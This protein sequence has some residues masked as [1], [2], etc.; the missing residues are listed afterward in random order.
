MVKSVSTFSGVVSAA[1]GASTMGFVFN[2]LER[3]FKTTLLDL[4]FLFFLAFF[5]GTTFLGGLDSVAGITGAF[6]CTSDLTGLMGLLR[7]FPL[8]LSL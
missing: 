2:G 8:V 7:P 4:M 3:G 5:L 6:D 1:G